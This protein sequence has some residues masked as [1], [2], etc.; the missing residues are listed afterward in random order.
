MGRCSRALIA[1]GCER[2]RRASADQRSAHGN[3]GLNAGRDLDP[4]ALVPQALHIIRHRETKA[5]SL[6]MYG[7]M[8]SVL[9]LMTAS[10]P[11]YATLKIRRAPGAIAANTIGLKRRRSSYFLE[12]FKRTPAPTEAGGPGQRVKDGEHAI[13]TRL[14]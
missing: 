7:V 12:A 5:I 10:R 13:E 14:T 6:V 4:A 3:L 8:P 2:P 11:S 1:L 9:G